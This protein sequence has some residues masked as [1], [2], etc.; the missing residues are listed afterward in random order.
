[1]IVHF[2]RLDQ[3]GEGVLCQYALHTAISGYV[4]NFWDHTGEAQ[5]ATVARDIALEKLNQWL[6]DFISISRIAL[7]GTP[8]YLEMLGIVEAAA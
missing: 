4:G 1:V 8:Q 7:E 2:F 3:A 5:N 6:G